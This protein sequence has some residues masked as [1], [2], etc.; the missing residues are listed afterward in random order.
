MF[1]HMT[2]ELKS[3]YRFPSVSQKYTPFA[4]V[5]GIGDTFDWADQVQKLCSRESGRIS[6]S[7]MSDMNV[8]YRFYFTPSAAIAIQLYQ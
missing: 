1:T 4:F 3:R 6:E 2:I 7:E 8:L 5:T